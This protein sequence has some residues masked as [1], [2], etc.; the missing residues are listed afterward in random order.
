LIYSPAGRVTVTVSRDGTLLALRTRK[1]APQKQKLPSLDSARQVN[2]RKKMKINLLKLNLLSA[3]LATSLAGT[4]HATL[5]WNGSA[6][7]GTAVFGNMNLEGSATCTVI[8]DSTYGQIF[9]FNKPSGSGR[10]EA[11]GANGFDPARGSTYYIG[12]GFKLTSLVDNN[13]IFQWKSYG[14][15]MTQ[16]Y[17]VVLKMNGGKLKLQYTPPGQSSVFIWEK[18]ISANTWYK[19]YLKINVSDSTSGGSVSL[20]YNDAAQ[21][22]SNG[23]SSYT[24]RTFDGSSVDPK[25]GVYGATS[26]SIHDYIRHLRI[27]SALADVQF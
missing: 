12:W 25:W 4:A 15:P 11:H 2:P 13:A 6:S 19:I 1:R 23:S 17:P 24:C 14:S 27:G 18:T 20:W 9:D 16:N 5:I 22:F 21:T 8:N 26:T 10:C 7:G 3:F